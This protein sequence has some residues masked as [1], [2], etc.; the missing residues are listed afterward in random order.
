M[1]RKSTQETENI[2]TK[3]NRLRAEENSGK[4]RFL[5]KIQDLTLDESS[6]SLGK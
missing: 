6:I 2:L 5:S 3:I 1:E 4:E